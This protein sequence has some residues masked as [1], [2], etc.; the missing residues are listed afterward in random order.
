MIVKIRRSEAVR[1]MMA[2]RKTQQITARIARTLLNVAVCRTFLRAVFFITTM[3]GDGFIDR[4]P[5]I[6]TADYRVG[7]GG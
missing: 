6:P 7:I 4:S 3:H 5:Q 1:G 2:R